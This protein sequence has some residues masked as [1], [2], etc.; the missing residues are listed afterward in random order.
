MFRIWP[1]GNTALFWC[2]QTKIRFWGWVTV[3][4]YLNE[5]EALH[6]KEVLEKQEK[7]A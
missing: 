3:K 7:S 6:I 1:H 2:V 5:N 4:E